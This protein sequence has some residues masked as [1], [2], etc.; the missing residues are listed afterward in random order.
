ML[1]HSMVAGGIPV[2]HDRAQGDRRPTGGQSEMTFRRLQAGGNAINWG[3]QSSNPGPLRGSVRQCQST[4]S[5]FLNLD[6]FNDVVVTCEPKLVNH[7][8]QSQN[9][10]K[11]AG[12]GQE[13]E[14]VRTFHPKE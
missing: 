7:R 12:C 14:H 3:R 9:K 4:S 6:E 13:K 8:V 11:L 5:G 1:V 2:V 10:D